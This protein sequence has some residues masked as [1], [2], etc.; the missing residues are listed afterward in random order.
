MNSDLLEVDS[1]VWT[2]KDTHDFDIEHIFLV[3]SLKGSPPTITHSTQ[4]DKTHFLATMET[5]LYEQDQAL[6]N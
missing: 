3:R 2:I 1:K 6:V 5:Y 4:V